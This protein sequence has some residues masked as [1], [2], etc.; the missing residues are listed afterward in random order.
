MDDH[1]FDYKQKS[2][3]K[4]K[5]QVHNNFFFSWRNSLKS[6]IINERLENQVFFWRL[7]MA[8]NEGGKS[9]KLPYFHI[10]FSVCKNFFYKER[11]KDLYF[12]FGLV[13]VRIF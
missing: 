2:K 13:C 6:E 4:K 11:N 3:K 9:Q 5:T 10:W 7:S 1:H 12:I 8:R